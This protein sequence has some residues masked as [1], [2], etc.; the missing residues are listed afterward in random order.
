MNMKS[1]T[2]SF[3]LTLLFSVLGLF[4]ASPLAAVIVL[5]LAIFT[6]WIPFAI[7]F[8]WVLA[9]AIG[10]HAVVAH[11]RERERFIKELKGG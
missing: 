8:W 9:I 7:L 10:D 5:V 2:T 1:R 4:Y 3:I 11:N 6:A